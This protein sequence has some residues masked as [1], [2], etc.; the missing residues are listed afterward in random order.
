[1]LALLSAHRL[2][3]AGCDL[4]STECAG[5]KQAVHTRSAA[6]SLRPKHPWNYLCEVARKWLA[7]LAH[8]F[9]DAVEQFEQD[10]FYRILLCGDAGQH[11]DLGIQL[12]CDF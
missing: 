8:L 5:S 6:G 7:I 3:V 12:E 11:L 9:E 10:V 4:N 1:M 2:P